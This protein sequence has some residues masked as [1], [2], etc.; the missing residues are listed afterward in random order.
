VLINAQT[1]CINTPI[2]NITYATT[3]ATGATFTGLPAGV[4]GNWAANVVTI[5]GT[6][7]ATGT[8]NYTVTLTGGCG[9]ITA[10]GT[11]TVNGGP[12]P[13]YWNNL[14][15]AGANVFPFN[16]LPATGKKVQWV[17][18]AGEFIMPSPAPGGNEITSIWFRPNAACNATYN[19]LTIRMATVSTSTFITTGAFYSGPM[20]TVLSQNTTIISTGPLIWTE[21]PLTTP[22]PYDPTMNL[23]IEVS[24][25]GFTGTGFNINQQGY[26]SAPNYRRQYSDASS[27]CGVTALPTG[28]DLNIAAI[29]INIVPA[30]TI[31]LS[32]AP[33]TDAQTVCVNTPITNITYNTTGATGA[34]FSGLPAGVTGNWLANVATISGTPTAS[35]TFNYAV[36]LTGGG[37]GVVT[38]TGSI[39]VNPIPNAIATPSSQTVCSGV[40]ITTIV[41][42]GAVGGTTFNWTRDN[43]GPV[44]G[45]AA[46]GAGNISG[47]LTNTTNAPVTVTFTITPTANGCPGPTTTATVLVNPTPNAVILPIPG[48]LQVIITGNGGFADEITWTLKN[49]LNATILSGGPYGFNPPPTASGTAPATN[50]PFTFFITSIGFFN[51]NSCL[52][53]VRC[54]GSIVASGCIQGTSNGGG[55]ASVGTLT[56]PNISGCSTPAPSSQTICSGSSITPLSFTGNVSGTVFNWS[57]DN[58]VAVTGI[59]ASGSG[60]ISGT[61]TNTTN[62]PV[63][64]TFTITPTANGCSGTPITATVIVN[65]I[66]NAVATPSSQ[67]ICSGTAMTTIVLS[68]NVS[69]TVFNWTRSN[70]VNVTG[71]ANSGSGD[72]SG[73]PI[74]NTTVQQTVTYTITPVAN[75]CTGPSITATLIV[76]K[77]PAITCPANITVNNAPGLCGATVTYPPATATGSPAPVITYSQASGTFFPVGTTTVT[78]TATN[79]CGVATCTFTITVVDA[80]APTITCPVNIVRNTDVGLCTATIAVPNPTNVADNCAVTVVSWVMSG[81]TTGASPLTGINY[82]GTQTFNLNGTTGQGITT[83]VYTVKDAAGNTTTCTFTVTVNDAWIPVISIQ[84]TTQ[85]V[86]VGSNAAFTVT[87]S[88][89][90]GNPLTYKWQTWNGS[91]WVDISPA[92]TAA[93]LPFS[94]VPFSLNTTD[95]RCILTGRCSVVTSAVA[96]L[97]V[98][99]LPTISLLA[100]RPLALLPG[101]LLNITAVVSPGGGTYQWKKNS[102][103]YTGP[104]ATSNMLSGLSVSDI[105]IYTCTYTDGNGC[106]STSAAMEITGLASDGLYVYPVPNNGSFHVRFYNQSGEE[107]TIRVFDMKGT[108][109]YQKKVITTIAYT[110]IPIDMTTAQIIATETYLV[111]VR[112][113]NGRLIGARKIQILK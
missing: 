67:T 105:G 94:A 65:P 69:G 29:G 25:C 8:F 49:S 85:T 35:G 57:R 88:V 7:T 99:P 109:V 81:A 77:A 4:T 76:N 38:A 103:N 97:Y 74:N 96:T 60:T 92:Q 32:S 89:P 46:S 86:C 1:V 36:T 71:I 61:L 62:A 56:V 112:G 52:W 48:S 82:V 58:T 95:Y 80:E 91:A 72:I 5:S 15:T 104:G 24:Q 54:N 47:T 23:I 42:S 10:L 2:T 108:L 30:C 37:C 34:T 18:A 21:I 87:A 111:E 6:P 14:P 66:P 101:Q 68:G 83:I 63:T 3:G 107:V 31:T 12:S 16:T 84:P 26:G 27:L 13:Q 70:T 20:T 53:E 106:V 73:T 79:I 93:T 22:F 9:S 113:N 90:A 98:N 19:T 33:G 51:D 64:V 28:G 78:A 39:I 110:D 40:P 44:T 75:G 43:T 102:S 100:S 59:P 45:I 17:I 11:I 55:C 41:L 50:A